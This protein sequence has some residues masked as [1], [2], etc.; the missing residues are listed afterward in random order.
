MQTKLTLRVDSRL[1][2]RAKAY[3]SA[4]GRSVSELVADYFAVL[5][6]E[7]REVP[8]ALPEIVRS[9]HGC[10]SGAKVDEADYARFIESKYDRGDL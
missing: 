9:L 10:L 3:A 7:E 5:G 1:I 2:E 8:E 4:T 6:A